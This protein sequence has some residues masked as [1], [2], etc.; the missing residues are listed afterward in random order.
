MSKQIL[1]S[2]F[3]ISK[4]ERDL[5]TLVASSSSKRN[6]RYQIDARSPSGQDFLTIQRNRKY[7]STESSPLLIHEQS[8]ANRKN[9]SNLNVVARSGL[10]SYLRKDESIQN[11]GFQN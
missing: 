7:M 11:L 2:K 1:K 9:N 3:D 10:G 6:T 8:F 4:N 5:N